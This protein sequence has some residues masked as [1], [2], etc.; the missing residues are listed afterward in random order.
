[1]C[2]F[3]VVN[4]R[5]QENKLLIFRSRPLL[6]TLRLH[7]I[8]NNV[9]NIAAGTNIS[10]TTSAVATS[11][12]FVPSQIHKHH[13]AVD[14]IF[15]SAITIR[16]LNFGPYAQQIT[17]H[18]LLHEKFRVAVHN[19]VY[20]LVLPPFQHQ[21]RVFPLRTKSVGFVSS[22]S[23]FY[24]QR[25]ETLFHRTKNDKTTHVSR[26]T[27]RNGPQGWWLRGRNYTQH[28]LNRILFFGTLGDDFYKK[29]NSRSDLVLILGMLKRYRSA[30][31]SDDPYTMHL[32]SQID[33]IP[34]VAYKPCLL[35]TTP[36]TSSGG[37]ITVLFGFTLFFLLTKRQ[38][39][40][41]SLIDLKRQL[42][43]FRAELH[44][45]TLQASY[46]PLLGNE[47]TTNICREFNRGCSKIDQLVTPTQ[48][49]ITKR[50]DPLG[51]KCELHE[52]L[53]MLGLTLVI[54][55]SNLIVLTYQFLCWG[56]QQGHKLPATVAGLRQGEIC[57]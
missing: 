31:E 42:V 12:V 48:K 27:L 26:T 7:P 32:W 36:R 17:S 3:A 38:H 30:E 51:N 1:M 43:F 19:T 47:M 35:A 41:L 22:N 49:I 45:M 14:L 15:D 18:S 2:S 40:P 16:R 23:H 33:P 44:K 6:D 10:I 37:D 53:V 9:I 52:S 57:V 46:P 39:A 4:S 55:I 54:Y 20:K 50:Q 5:S 29:L 13:R 34:N 24:S 21:F 25:A 8:I 28:F 56:T 11:I